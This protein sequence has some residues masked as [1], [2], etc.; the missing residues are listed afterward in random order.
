MNKPQLINF[1]EFDKYA[2]QS[3]C[4]IHDIDLSLN[5]GDITKVNEKEIADFN[6]MTWGFP[7]QDIS[8]AGKQK[9]FI[10]EAG[11][12]TRSG[13]YYEGIRILREKKPALSIVE[14][15]KALT[16]KKFKNEFDMVLKD[17]DE[18]GYNTYWQILN[19][20]DY[21]IPQ[22]R[23]RVFLISIRKDL[24]NGK[25][26]FP[27]GFDN[28]LRLKDLLDDEVD[29]KYYLSDDKL[30]KFLLDTSLL[31]KLSMSKNDVDIVGTVDGKNFN[32]KKAI[33]NPNC[34]SGTLIGQGHCGN[35][36]KILCEIDKP[37]NNP[38]LIE[39]ANYIT[40]RED[41]GISNRKSEGTAV[42][43]T[44]R[45]IQVADLNH[46][47]NDQM[48]R[49]YGTDGIFP[50]VMTKTGGG[51]EIKILEEQKYIDNISEEYSFVKG[52]CQ[53]FYNKNSYLPEMFNPYNQA[54]IMD[55]APTQTSQCTRPS[56]SSAVLIKNNISF[57][58]R[59]LTPKE[60]WR[61]M[62]FNDE[63][64]DKAKSAGVSDS[65]LYKQA[66]NSIV[67]YVLYEIYKELYKAMP[68][69]FDDI[70]LSSFFSGIGAFEIAL[71]MFYKYIITGEE[72]NFIQPQ[73]EFNPLVANINHY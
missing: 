62:G 27:K 7:C 15:V 30:T 32:Q 23:E 73:A 37:Y 68:Y 9:G 44:N 52:K 26:V 12:K 59:K 24:D 45:C 17:L 36:P 25:F 53:E 20:K 54:E 48:N 29:E 5:L 13:M 1:C 6:M 64:F 47:G 55:I 57:K 42:I 31:N 56:S 16:S 11:N 4:A 38:E 14:N 50:T 34:I 10:D 40:T 66:G 60:C 21:G 35:E 33:Y 19:A 70:K 46:C 2:A 58:V 28:G 8:A 51:R 39:T 18:A 22:N 41:R 63:C 43:E 65:Q 72:Q 67:T 69:L 71:D 3:Y 49:L 61:L